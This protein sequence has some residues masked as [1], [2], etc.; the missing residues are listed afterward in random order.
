MSFLTDLIAC[1]TGGG[2]KRPEGKRKQC[3]VIFAAGW[4]FRLAGVRYSRFMVCMCAGGPSLLREYAGILAGM[5][6]GYQLCF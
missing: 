1:T 2:R 6:Y 4:Y 5:D 3:S